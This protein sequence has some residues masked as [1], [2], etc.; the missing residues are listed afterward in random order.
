[1]RTS[2]LLAAAVVLSLIPTAL[3]A[4]AQ[5]VIVNAN[6]PG[7][8]FND[9]TSAAP[10]G[11]NTGTT[12]GE[13]R[14]KAFQF[15]A[16]VWGRTLDSSVPV[17][18]LA[19]FE[20]LTCTATGAVLGSA[21]A[22]TIWADFPG[23]GLSPG[24]LLP[25]TWH[26]GALANKRAGF[27]LDPAEPGYGGEDLRARFNV[28]LGNAGCLTGTGWY[29][30]LDANHGTNIDLVAVLL[31]EFAHG[32]GFQ[33]FASVTNGSQILGLPDVY[34]VRMFDKT[35]SLFWPQMTNAQR[36]ASAIN[37]RRVIFTGE[38]V[39]TAIPAVLS[40]GT[41]LLRVTTPAAIA[42]LYDVGAASFGPALSAAG[43]SGSVVLAQD[44]ANAGGPSTTDGCTVLTNAAAV[45]GQIAI[46]DRGTCAFAVKVKN[47]QLA[48]A[49]AVL[50]A[51]NAAGGPPAGLGGA[52]ATITIPSVR[53]TLADGNLIKGQL[54]AGVGVT[55]GVDMT[56]RAGA[57][58]DGRALLNA[59]N[60]VQPG[61][62]ISHWD[63]IASRNQLM[64]PAINGDLTHNVKPPF[65]LSLPLMRDIGWFPDA[66]LDG[67]ADSLD[68]CPTS[69]RRSGV[70]V[71]TVDTGVANVLFT[72]GCTIG[73]LIALEA[74]GARNH[75]G[76]VSGV[77]H[78]LN[79]LRDGGFITDEQK[80]LI[81]STAAKS[82][83]P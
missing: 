43:V 52:D 19:T 29:L 61:S 53:I 75:G 4:S 62:S 33:Q 26:G 58:A 66:D 41:P 10:V 71:G 17:L 67:L 12:L 11:G 31:H 80:G 27:D 13:Q 5:V 63:P 77:A 35:T 7:V 32:L 20:P 3:F 14:L 54:A 9:P 64:E 73:D 1:M 51:D 22:L 42:G 83:L 81:Q 57:D 38:N 36:A 74:A 50:V 72:S 76:F 28:N 68:S 48:G 2:R 25:G 60:P 8:G 21:G 37:S 34:N 45:A 24:A 18:V 70:Y 69:D 46:L 55:L 79:A 30:G 39:T 49:I 82:K 15:A 6:A 65:D 47:A 40:L 56:V 16:D 59:P 78:L 44:A 23:V